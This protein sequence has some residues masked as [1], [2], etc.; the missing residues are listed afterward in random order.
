MCFKVIFFRK[1]G[2]KV[3]EAF[4]SGIYFYLPL[5]KL[6]NYLFLRK[7]K[8]DRIAAQ[9]PEICANFMILKTLGIYCTMAR[10]LLH[11]ISCGQ[12]LRCTVQMIQNKLLQVV[13]LELHFVTR[14]Y[15]VQW[16]L[17]TETKCIRIC[18]DHDFYSTTSIYLFGKCG[19][20]V[21]YHS[22]LTSDSS[23]SLTRVSIWLID[24][25]LQWLTNMLFIWH[26]DT[27]L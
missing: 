4:F 24:T 7:E 2:A 10:H 9:F 14:K 12:Q 6:V 19:S 18:S 11:K 25:R 22:T 20:L 13:A 26:T 15:I 16:S 5:P 3:H 8:S 21:V 27:R 23:G 17:V 1:Y